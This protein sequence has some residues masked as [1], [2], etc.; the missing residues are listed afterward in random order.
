M[1]AQTGTLRHVLKSIISFSPLT[2]TYSHTKSEAGK[3]KH[4]LEEKLY[5]GKCHH[6]HNTEH[7]SNTT[8]TSSFELLILYCYFIYVYMYLQLFCPHFPIKKG[9]R[10]CPSVNS[11]MFSSSFSH[12]TSTLES[13]KSQQSFLN[14]PLQQG[15]IHMRCSMQR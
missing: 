5:T 13:G 8:V 15:G 10:C 6:G 2:F 11:L 14:H 4:T 12:V 7:E 3:P 9:V 1:V